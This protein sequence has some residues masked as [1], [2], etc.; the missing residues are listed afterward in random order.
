MFYIAFKML[1]GDRGKYLG[2]ILGISFASLIM[3]QQPAIFL[4]LMTRTYS[5]ITDLSLPDI[6]VMEPTVRFLDDE[7]LMPEKKSISRLKY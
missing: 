1:V 7:K 2:I 6:W 4:G 3:T 5:F